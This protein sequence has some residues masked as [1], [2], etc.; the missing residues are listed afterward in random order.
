MCVYI[1]R[2]GGTTLRLV[3]YVC[4]HYTQTYLYQYHCKLINFILCSVHNI[5]TINLIYR[6]PPTKVEKNPSLD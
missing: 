2:P 4:R 5:L 3:P 6:K 1:G